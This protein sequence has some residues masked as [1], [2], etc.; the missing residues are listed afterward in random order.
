MSIFVRIMHKKIVITVAPLSIEYAF[1]CMLRYL[2]YPKLRVTTVITSCIGAWCSVCTHKV[3]SNACLLQC[4]CCLHYIHSNCTNLLKIDIDEILSSSRSW[5]CINC[6]VHLFPFNHIHDDADF[7]RSYCVDLNEQTYGKLL[8]DKIFVPFELN[9]D[10]TLLVPDVDV[11]P[12]FNFFNQCYV[13]SN[14]QC[15]YYLGDGLS[16]YTANLLNNPNECFSV[17]DMNN[18]SMK[19]NLDS[20]T[21]YLNTLKF[22]FDVI[23]LTE[24]LLHKDNSDPPIMHQVIPILAYLVNIPKAV[25]FLYYCIPDS[26]TKDETL[27][28]YLWKLLLWKK[29]L[30]V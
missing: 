11:D 12:D 10:D 19:A 22:I 6:N 1:P 28:V 30:L 4:D 21:A 20:F 29:F 18:R 14:I 17:I 8:S 13:Q 7:L 9:E 27:N 24:T 15:K 5:S 2:L 26:H 3:P 23:G 16:K 25:V